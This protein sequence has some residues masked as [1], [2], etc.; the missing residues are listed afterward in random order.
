MNMSNSELANLKIHNYRRSRKALI[1]FDVFIA[2]T[3]PMDKLEDLK[4]AILSFLKARPDIWHPRLVTKLF[5][6]DIAPSIRLTLQVAPR[7][8][9]QEADTINAHRLDLTE[10]IRTQMMNLDIASGNAI[11]ENYM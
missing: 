10:D 4:A 5:D 3:T 1:E 11:G 7:L 9:W 6:L 8:A 2:R